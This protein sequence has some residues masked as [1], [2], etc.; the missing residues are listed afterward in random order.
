MDDGDDPSLATLSW[1]SPQELQK[2]PSSKRRVADRNPG[3][4]SYLVAVECIAT[5]SQG[6]RSSPTTEASVDFLRFVFF[7]VK[8][9]ETLFRK[10]NIRPV[11][12]CDACERKHPKQKEESTGVN[13]RFQVRTL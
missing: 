6:S 5:R 9:S 11:L 10:N 4:K 3:V 7:D 13:M 12:R 2:L 1:G 8:S